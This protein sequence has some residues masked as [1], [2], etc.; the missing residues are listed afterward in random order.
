M[1]CGSPLS[2][3]HSHSALPQPHPGLLLFLLPVRHALD[4]HGHVGGGNAGVARWGVATALAVL[5]CLGALPL[6]PLLWLAGRLDP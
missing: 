1:N 4:A 6:A 5:L 3:G 2:C